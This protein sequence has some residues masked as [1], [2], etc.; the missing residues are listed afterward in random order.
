MTFFSSSECPD[1]CFPSSFSPSPL[2]SEFQQALAPLEMEEQPEPENSSSSNLSSRLSLPPATSSMFSYTYVIPEPE[3]ISEHEH[4]PVSSIPTSPAVFNPPLDSQS[5]IIVTGPGSM[6]LPMSFT[7]A[8]PTRLSD[9]DTSTFNLPSTLAPSL[10]FPNPYTDLECLLSPAPSVTEAGLS[11]LASLL[12]SACSSPNIDSPPVFPAQKFPHLV[13]L[14]SCTCQPRAEVFL[15]A[16]CRVTLLEVT[17]TL[18]SPAN[19]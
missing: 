3:P 4:T 16:R 9:G 5:G 13:V 18:P 17:S 7:P 8:S 11:G 19:A 1:R 15:S 12:T 6:P 14:V 10:S 2:P